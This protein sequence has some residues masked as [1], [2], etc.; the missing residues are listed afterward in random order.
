VVLQLKLSG[1]VEQLQQQIAAGQI[2]QLSP[3]SN[4]QTLH[5]Q[6]L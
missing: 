4:E 3:N 5:Y 6:Y 1:S 2:L